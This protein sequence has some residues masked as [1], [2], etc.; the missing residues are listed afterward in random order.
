MTGRKSLKIL[1]EHT[2]RVSHE[3]LLAKKKKAILAR[4]LVDIQNV[5]PRV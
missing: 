5:L 2:L 1:V 3:K 4:K